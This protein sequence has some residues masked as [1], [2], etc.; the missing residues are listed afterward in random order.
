MKTLIALVLLASL[1]GC[2]GFGD[3]MRRAADSVNHG[4]A[5]APDATIQI[6]R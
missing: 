1:T 3:N 2:A 5:R 6:Q 4:V